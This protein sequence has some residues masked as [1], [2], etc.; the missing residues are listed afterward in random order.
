MLLDIPD[1]R[2]DN[3]KWY[4]CGKVCARAVLKYYNVD[5]SYSDRLMPTEKSGTSLG[6]L[7][8]CFEL[9]GRQV[10]QGTMS[11]DLLRSIKCPV[12]L[13]TISESI[14]HYVVYRGIARQRVYVFD[15]DCGYVSSPISKFLGNWHSVDSCNRPLRQYGMIIS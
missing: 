3:D 9:A 4:D 2:T 11:L 15:P 10:C 13:C 8:L 7:A 1:A 6:D 5:L 12:I 14:D